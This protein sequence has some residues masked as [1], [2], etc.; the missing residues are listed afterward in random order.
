MLTGVL[1]M[2]LANAQELAVL[3]AVKEGK[4]SSLL[5]KL[6]RGVSD[7]HTQRIFGCESETTL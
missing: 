6:C 5:V 2:F 7:P 3:R 4:T 1:S